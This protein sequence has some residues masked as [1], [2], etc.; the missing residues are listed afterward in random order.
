MAKVK[1]PIKAALAR[2]LPIYN[3]LTN[4]ADYLIEA[5]QGELARRVLEFNRDLKG[6]ERSIKP[7][8]AT[9]NRKRQTGNGFS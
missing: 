8:A 3:H 5:G 4:M 1:Y 2:F 7:L 9:E 6:F